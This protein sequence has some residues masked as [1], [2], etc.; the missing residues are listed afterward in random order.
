MNNQFLLNTDTFYINFTSN[1]ITFFVDFCANCTTHFDINLLLCKNSK[2]SM[3]DTEKNVI[4]SFFI[5]N[6]QDFKNP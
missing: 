6:E 4:L 2:P 5:L 3:N 1:S